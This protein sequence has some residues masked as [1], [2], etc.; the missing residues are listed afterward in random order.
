MKELQSLGL[1]IELE[2]DDIEELSLANTGDIFGGSADISDPL[3]LL[4]GSPLLEVAGQDDTGARRI[5]SQPSIVLR[6]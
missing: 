5:S 2:K 1:A 4:E 6:H 3:A